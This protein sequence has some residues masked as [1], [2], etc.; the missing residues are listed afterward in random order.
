MAAHCLFGG[1]FALAQERKKRHLRGEKGPQ[2]AGKNER[3][4]ERNDEYVERKQ[5]VQERVGKREMRQGGKGDGAQ[6]AGNREGKKAR[7]DDKDG[8]HVCKKR[9]LYPFCKRSKP[10]SSLDASTASSSIP[11]LGA[12]PSPE[13][14]AVCV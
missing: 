1:P 6:S 14:M 4:K 11:G 3:K 10:R 2:S 8:N 9:Q 12:I 5:E 13:I 7:K